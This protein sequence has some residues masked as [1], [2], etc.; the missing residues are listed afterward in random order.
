MK[1]NELTDAL[2]SAKVKA[3]LFIEQTKHIKIEKYSEQAAIRNT[4]I[5]NNP[6]LM[7][8]YQVL[9][10]YFDSVLPS[11]K[12]KDKNYGQTVAS[13]YN[14]AIARQLTTVT[15][16]LQGE[17]FVIFI[18]QHFKDMQ[19]RDLDN[20]NRKLLIDAL[21]HNLVFKDDSYKY[22]S[23]F[24]EAYNVRNQNEM[25]VYIV[26]KVNFHH[27]LKDKNIANSKVIESEINIRKQALKEYAELL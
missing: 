25:I 16:N 21:R 20:R 1:I 7:N 14:L 6:I 5:N 19:L 3:M 2:D 24:E 23:I 18:E 12:T 4:F 11:Y 10:F 26:E 17:E 15:Q 8:D 22:I 9:M 13:Y 27:F